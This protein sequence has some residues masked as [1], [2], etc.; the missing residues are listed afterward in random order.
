MLRVGTINAALSRQIGQ[1]LANRIDM[2]RVT[3]TSESL[4]T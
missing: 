3:V 4:L 2:N 1:P